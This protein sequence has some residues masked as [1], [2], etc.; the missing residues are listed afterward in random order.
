[1]PPAGS[2]ARWTLIPHA[3]QTLWKWIRSVNSRQSC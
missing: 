1:M 3:T 2:E